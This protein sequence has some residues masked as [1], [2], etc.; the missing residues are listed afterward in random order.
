MVRSTGIP[1]DRAV[2]MIGR[3][4]R[5]RSDPVTFTRPTTTTNSLDEEVETTADHTENAW[6]YDASEAVGQEIAGERINGALG[7]FIYSDGSVDVQLN[8][9]VTYGGVTYK[10]DSVVGKP[11]DNDADGTTSDGTT[12]FIVDLVRRQ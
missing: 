3:I 4:I 10:V 11:T 2:G 8:D 6:L 5:T 9:R 1:T 7:A 12:Y